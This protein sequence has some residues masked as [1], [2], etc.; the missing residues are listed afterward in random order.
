MTRTMQAAVVETFGQPLALREVPIPVPGPGEVLIDVSACGVCHT[1]LHAAHGDWPVKPTLPFIP[2]HEVTGH[3]VA[4]GPGTGLLREGDRVGVPWLQSTCGRCEFCL[5][6]RETLCPFQTNTGYSVNGGFAEFLIAAAG[7]ATKIPDELGFDDA[8]PILCAGVTTY[9][10]LKETDSHP[11]DWVVISGV[12]GLGHV[13]VQYAVAMGYRVIAVDIAGDKLDLARALGAEITLN[14]RLVDPVDE[15]QRLVCG[16]HGALVTAV[17]PTAVSQA[18]G[19]MRRGGTVSLVGLPPG[20]FETPI[21]DVVLKG[22][23]IRGSIVGT[24]SDLVEALD[25]AARGKVRATFE[26]QPL[27]AIN[28]IFGRLESGDINGRVVLQL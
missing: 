19:M 1:D 10:G 16:A 5:T 26:T 7:F 28:V 4:L 9:K 8:A 6:G 23:T 25:F 14:A 20:T 3:V 22:L 15:V 17:S 2:G 11:G 24:R 18:I 21:F 13:A 12:G 27:E